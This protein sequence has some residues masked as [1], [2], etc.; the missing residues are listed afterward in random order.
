VYP[1]APNQLDTVGPMAKDVTH[2]VVGM[3]L[4]QRGFAAQYRAATSA[5]PSAQGIKIGRF[6]VDGTDPKIDR[7]V[8][9]ALA[10][11]G[12]RVVVLDQAFKAKW[13]QAMKDGRTVAAA[14]AWLSDEK[15]KSQP[16]V[17]ART[18]AVVALG[19]Y[20]YKANYHSALKRQA[21]W[22]RTLREVFKNVDFIALPTLKTLPSGI[23]LFGGTPAFEALALSRQNT[24]AVN[25][26][27]NPALAIPIPVRDRAVPVTSL[28]LIGPRLSEAQLLNAGRLIES[29]P[30]TVQ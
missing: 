2:L 21:E 12:F 11:K 14:S 20:E 9:D 24:V 27:G 28:Q 5:R 25:F 30:P 1:I 16:G 22:Q 6:Y 18:K 15:F 7:A 3:D 8:D 29:R 4:L 13:D 23:P 26:A 19:E 17:N 10:A